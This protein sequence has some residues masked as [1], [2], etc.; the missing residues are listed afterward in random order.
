MKGAMVGVGIYA[1]NLGVKALNAYVLKTSPLTG[2]AETAAKVGIGLIALPMLLRFVP[3]GSKF[4]GPVMLGAG[5]VVA[6]DLLEQFMTP[7]LPAELHGY[8]MMSG[9][10]QDG[11]A[12]LTGPADGGFNTGAG[13]MYR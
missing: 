7:S 9:Y 8:S 1:V 12:Q 10:A 6:L 5:A 11:Q 3:G 13:G 4:A 2:Y